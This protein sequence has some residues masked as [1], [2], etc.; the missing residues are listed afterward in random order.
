MI[1]KYLF[2]GRLESRAEILT[3]WEEKGLS[4]EKKHSIDLYDTTYKGIV[5]Q[6]QSQ[7][8]FFTKAD[9]ND[10]GNLALPVIQFNF[11]EIELSVCHSSPKYVNRSL[12][13][14]EL[15]S[16]IYNSAK[17]SS[18]SF[19]RGV[20]LSSFTAFVHE[21]DETCFFLLIMIPFFPHLE[22]PLLVP[23]LSLYIHILLTSKIQLIFL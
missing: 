16:G 4:H 1:K 21:S 17:Y 23:L 12:S 9:D 5:W 15:I 18:N 7:C 22:I 20:L 19:V 8:F 2:E 14:M 13:L 10:F 3:Q 11:P 6:R